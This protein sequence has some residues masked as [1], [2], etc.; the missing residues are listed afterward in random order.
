MFLV[1][2]RH[3][4]ATAFTLRI[5]V[6]PLPFLE[7]PEHVGQRRVRGHDRRFAEHDL[8]YVTGDVGMVIDVLGNFPGCRFGIL[9]E[10]PRVAVKLNMGQV[11]AP[12]T[13]GF[14]GLQGGLEVAAMA[15]VVAMD[16]RRVWQAQ[17]I[18]RFHKGI[19]HLPRRHLNEVAFLI[20]VLDV[21]ILLALPGFISARVDQLGRVSLGCIDP[22]GD[23]LA[24]FLLAP[25]LDQLLQE[26][27]IA[28]QHVKPLVYDRRIMKFFDGMPGADWGDG[29]LHGGGVAQ[30][31]IAVPR[32]KGGRNGAARA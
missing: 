19:D 17:F 2:E 5:G 22:P 21:G 6:Y 7:S 4:T 18:D 25:V 14:H 3:D 20:D 11:R 24:E 13:G 10:F 32:G 12:V 23:G 16:M 30:G 1:T 28:Q 29:R 8:A 31:G 15:Q 9:A 27:I 26:D